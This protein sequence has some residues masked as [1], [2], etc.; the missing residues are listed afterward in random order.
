MKKMFWIERLRVYAT[1]MVVINHCLA[2]TYVAINAGYSHLRYIIDVGFLITITKTA[3]PFFIMITGFLLLDPNKELPLNKLLKYIWKMVMVLLTF[4]LVFCLIESYLS[5]SQT[6]ILN[7]IVKAFINL[8]T[9]NCWAHMWYV[10][11]LIGL[12]IITPILRSFVAKTDQKTY[13]FTLI[14]LFVFTLLIPTINNYFNL[15]LTNLYL[16]FA[17]AVFFYLFGYYVKQVNVNKTLSLLLGLVSLSIVIFERCISTIYSAD[18]IN[19]DNALLAIFN[20]SIFY[21]L[22]SKQHNSESKLINYF[23]KRSFYI[24]LTHTIMINFF[25]KGLHIYLTDYPIIISTL[26]LFIISL[27]FSLLTYEIAKRLPIIK[28]II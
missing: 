5:Y 26:I 3:V 22:Y 13:K 27:A 17:P 16:N 4:G 14:C 24:Y 8:G 23:S 25:S 20:I 12:Y 21:L 18:L 9:G 7:V 19:Y 28:K 2:G 6:G 10:Y 1:M 15:Q 11:M